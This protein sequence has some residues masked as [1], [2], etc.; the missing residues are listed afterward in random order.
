MNGSYRVIEYRP[1]VNA[2]YHFR[3]LSAYP[4]PTLAE[5]SDLGFGSELLEIDTGNVFIYDSD[6]GKWEKL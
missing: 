6:N 1:G 3:G 5:Y 4:K 2:F